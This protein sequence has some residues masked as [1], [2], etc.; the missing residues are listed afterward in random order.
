MDSKIFMVSIL[1]SA[2]ICFVGGFITNKIFNYCNHTNYEYSCKG[3]SGIIFK[4]TNCG[5]RTSIRR[6]ELIKGLGYGKTKKSNN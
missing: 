1:V 5:K 3:V 4:C 2:P 6:K